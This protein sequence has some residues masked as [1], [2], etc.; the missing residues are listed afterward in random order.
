MRCPITYEKLLPDEYRYSVAGLKRLSPQLKSLKDFPYTMG[1][2]L[3]EANRMASKL[4]IQG[5]Q[6]KLS[7]ILNVSQETFDM[8]EQGGTYILKPQNPQWNSL[9]ENEDL[10]MRLASMVGI[11]VPVHGLLYCK[12]GALSYWIRRFDRPSLRSPMKQ[13][14][15]VEDFAQLGQEDRETKYNSSMERVA[16]IIR[17]FCTFPVLELEKLFHLTIFNF[18]VGNEDMHLKNF[19]LITR[20]GIVSLSPAYDL[21]NTTLA[22][23]AGVREEIALTLNG[24]KRKLKAEDFIDVYGQERLELSPQTIARILQSFQTNHP[25]WMQL[26]DKSFLNSEQK[27]GYK[28]ILNE[29]MSRLF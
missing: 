24:K 28:S 12:D 7:V 16:K 4:S 14:L 1:E 20:N 26:I 13:K 29:R 18:L 25:E 9:P 6:P 19:S 3:K 8:A 22:M 23:G 17:Q 27:I 11:D 15:N 10:T 21:L 5:V 2:Q